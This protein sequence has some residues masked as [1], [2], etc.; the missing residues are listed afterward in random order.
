MPLRFFLCEVPISVVTTHRHTTYTKTLL[1]DSIL[2]SKTQRTNKVMAHHLAPYSL[3][4]RDVSA[5]ETMNTTSSTFV[6]WISSPSRRGSIDILWAC[7]L[8]T[9]LCTWTS[10]HLN[11]P[12][13]GE[14]NLQRGLRRLRWLVQ[15][16]LAPEFILG[17][18]TGQKAE[19]R[20]SISLWKDSKYKEWTIHHGFYAT[21]GGFVL[22]PRDSKPFPVDYKQLHY[23]VSRGYVPFPD[24]TETKI[25]NMG[26]QDTFQKILTLLQLAWFIV[27]CIARAFQHLPITTLELATSGLVLCTL[28]SY[29]QWFHKPLD[30]QEVTII[31]SQKSTREILVEAGKF[32]NKTYTQTPLDFVDDSCPSWHAKIQQFLRSGAGELPLPRVPN[33]TVP[34]IG[35]NLDAAFLFTIVMIYSCLHTIAWNYHF[36][37][38]REQTIWRVNCI[39][40]IA[41]ASIFFSC[42]FYQGLRRLSEHEPGWQAIVSSAAVVIYTLARIYIAV[43]CFVSL[44][45]LPIGAFDSV[46]WSK[47]IPHF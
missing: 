11:I 36:P 13:L 39:I 38:Q 35:A 33:D 3:P 18:A 21:M 40:M 1:E 23:L 2:F 6:G 30:A 5:I 43:E 28:A 44:R 27:Q 47:F 46:R 10:L 24:I 12:G 32:S 45:S 9:F 25:R 22:Q 14:S 15:A 34:V 8:T 37:T 7:L 19:A 26:K 42:H 4:L 29:C 16:F 41:T 20:R 17:L 31:T